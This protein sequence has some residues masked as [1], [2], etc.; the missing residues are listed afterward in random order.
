M[1]YV[2]P[3]SMSARLGTCVSQ[4]LWAPCTCTG[5]R[6]LGVQAEACGCAGLPHRLRNKCEYSIIL[7][8][9]KVTAAAASAQGAPVLLT[10]AATCVLKQSKGSA[11]ECSRK[12][13][14][15]PHKGKAALQCLGP[16]YF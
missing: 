10:E 7:V 6:S 15:G 12:S 16:R 11:A 2:W 14:T 5:K 8:A 9:A 4:F 13:T 1:M 3:A